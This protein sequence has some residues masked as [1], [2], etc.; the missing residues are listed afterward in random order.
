MKKERQPFVIYYGETELMDIKTDIYLLHR[1]MDLVKEQLNS[2]WDK[3][4]KNKS[5][6]V[7]EIE[8]EDL[9]EKH[10]I[11]YEKQ[12]IKDLEKSLKNNLSQI[13]IN[14]FIVSLWSLYETVITDFAEILREKKGISKKLYEAD[15]NYFMARVVNYFEKD[16]E[17]NLYLSKKHSEDF[18]LLGDI[19]N[20]IAH[21]YG[22]VSA[23]R[24]QVQNNIRHKDYLELQVH[25]DKDKIIL[26][27][28]F[29]EHMFE[30]VRDHLLTLLNKYQ[31]VT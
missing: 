2:E 27:L 26:S 6:D 21:H 16:L 3:F 19:R 11:E 13:I 5:I 9:L 17:R 8:E 12:R 14:P 4:E 23:L 25:P 10:M 7:S 29:A 24:K 18:R 20:S 22:K 30:S 1:Q 15:G 28:K 31:N